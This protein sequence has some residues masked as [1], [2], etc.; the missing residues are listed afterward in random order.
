MK[1][2]VKLFCLLLFAFGAFSF[3]Q[4]E[5]RNVT[6]IIYQD[7]ELSQVE[8]K[9]YLHSYLPWVSGGEMDIWDSVQTRKGQ[10]IIELHG[11]TIFDNRFRVTFAQEGPNELY[12][13]A[14]PGDT[15]EIEACYDDMGNATQR[16]AIRG[17]V[18]NDFIEYDLASGA[19]W[20]K[21]HSLSDQQKAD[22]LRDWERYMTDFYCR[23]IKESPYVPIASLSWVF[24]KV[25]LQDQLGADSISA[26]RQHIAHRWPDD[27][28]ASLEFGSDNSQSERSLAARQLINDV[29]KEKAL[30]QRSR[31]D[32]QIGKT[33]SLNLEGVDGEK[34]ALSDLKDCRYIYVDV[35]ATWCKPCRAQCP[36]VK[37]ALT[38]YPHDLKVYAISIDNNHAGWRKGIEKDSLQDFVN[39]IGT[40][41]NRNQLP[42]VS[43]LG[44]KVIPRS[45]L[46]DNRCRIVAKDLHGEELMQTLDSLMAK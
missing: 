13:Y 31:K 10:K 43:R 44:V 12:V 42:E 8:Q 1:S 14:V 7:E 29:K 37:Q 35:W 27:I 36:Y 3:Q 45:F 24:L 20:K 19:L 11:Y 46:L 21:K 39:V 9:V 22:S 17:R 33:L 28:R 4:P 25:G 2:M 16:K 15:V 6:V 26:L 34:I 30:N 32:T 23:M 41:H 5:K 40:D 38:K 18:H